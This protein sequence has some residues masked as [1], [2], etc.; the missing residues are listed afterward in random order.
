S[1]AR[2]LSTMTSPRLPCFE[3]INNNQ[4]F[5]T[6]LSPLHERNARAPLVLSLFALRLRWRDGLLRRQL[7]GGHE[8]FFDIGWDSVQ[9]LKSFF[10][11][12]A[13]DSHFIQQLLRVRA[14]A[15]RF[16]R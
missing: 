10:Q 1:W 3:R 12:R 15:L 9:P 5:R 6:S 11:Y 16:E 13:Q 7:I 2:R 14:V 8:N 4:L